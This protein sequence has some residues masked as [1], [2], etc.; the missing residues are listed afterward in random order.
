MRLEYPWDQGGRGTDLE[1]DISITI[2]NLQRP[3]SP[4]DRQRGG[5]RCELSGGFAIFKSG[6]REPLHI[7]RNAFGSGLSDRRYGPSL[8]PPP[9]TPSSRAGPT[10][11]TCGF[12]QWLPRCP[13]CRESR[14]PRPSPSSLPSGA[15]PVR[16]CSAFRRYFCQHIRHGHTFLVLRDHRIL[17]ECLQFPYPMREFR[18]A[19]VWFSTRPLH[20]MLTNTCSDG[21]TPVCPVTTEYRPQ[22]GCPR[23]T[24]HEE[25]LREALHPSRNIPRTKLAKALKVHRNTLKRRIDD[26]GIRCDYST[27]EDPDLDLLIKGYKAKKPDS[28]F[29]YVRGT[30][31]HSDYVYKGSASW[32]PCSA[33]TSSGGYSEGGLSFEDGSISIP[34]PTLC[35][36]ATGITN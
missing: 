18:P 16:A 12:T 9:T 17:C 27:I 8:R 33:L 36:I 30:S 28:G 29:R 15:Y 13:S 14:A 22:R 26:L 11:G 35:G 23:K 1:D 4:N 2:V 10:P 32:I 19:Q 24:I 31:V 3:N 34:A 21:S 7:G 25:Y 5:H 6:R 20:P